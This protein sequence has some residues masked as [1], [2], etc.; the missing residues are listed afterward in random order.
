MA[1]Q[2]QALA[3]KLDYLGLLPEIHT[4][5]RGLI[6]THRDSLQFKIYLKS[7]CLPLPLLSRLPPCPLDLCSHASPCLELSS[8]HVCHWSLQTQ[9]RP[10]CSTLFSSPTTLY[11]SLKHQVVGIFLTCINT[12]LTPP[13]PLSFPLLRTCQYPFMCLCICHRNKCGSVV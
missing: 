5:E 8:P 4:V 1:Q 10:S 12:T 3:I 6:H 2:V 9:A 11:P 7:H 13:Q